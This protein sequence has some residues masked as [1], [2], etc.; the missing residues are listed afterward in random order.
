MCLGFFL[1]MKNL[2]LWR[3]LKSWPG[4]DEGIFTTELKHA[5][6]T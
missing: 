2:G 5:D 6:A 4:C 3:R 1:F